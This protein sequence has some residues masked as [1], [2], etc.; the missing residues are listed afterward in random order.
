MMKDIFTVDINTISAAFAITGQIQIGDIP[1]IKE[2]GYE[3]IICNRPDY[4]SE[5]QPKF[6][7]IRKA[8]EALDMESFYIPVHGTKFTQ[9]AIDAFSRILDRNVKVLAFCRTGNRSFNLLN[10]VASNSRERA[11]ELN[12]LA[13]RFCYKVLTNVTPLT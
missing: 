1:H 4:E 11:G 6:G 13:E 9:I 7:E 3:V 8:A 10:A 12:D 5:D 2:L